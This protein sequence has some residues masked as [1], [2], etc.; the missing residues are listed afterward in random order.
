VDLRQLRYFVAVAEELHFRRAAERL[1]VAQPAVSEQIRKLEQELGVK[2]FD[3]TQRKVSLTTAGGAFLEEAR[4]VLRHADVAAQAARTAGDLAT[5]PLRIGYLSDSLPAQ[6]PV[7]LRHLAT[8]AP[9]VQVALQSGPAL[10]LVEDL[11]AGRLDAVVTALPAPVGGLQVTP[12]GAQRAVLA[13]P[14][15]HSHADAVSVDLEQ[16]APERVIVL[17]RDTN[18]AFHNAVVSIAR[19]AGLAPTFVETPEP[20]V[21]QALLTVAAGGGVAL[22]PES[23][24]E[25]HTVP[26]VRFVPVVTPEPA[27]ETAVL[28]AR[29]GKSLATAAFLHSL[30]RATA[31]RAAGSRPA[32]LRRVA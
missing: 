30:T 9:R 24:A 1:H 13:V 21:E 25:R 14:A 16:L 27:F 11:R 3:R 18:P 15:T 10:R 8:S 5:M 2:L 4:H 17:P 22:L 7:A 29:E 28:T 32:A 31:V 23:A 26:G 20:S 6:V 19:D 12:L